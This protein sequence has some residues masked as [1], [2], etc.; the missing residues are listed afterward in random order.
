MAQTFELL[1]ETASRNSRIEANDRKA[2]SKRV[3]NKH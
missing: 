3:I 1:D 2:S